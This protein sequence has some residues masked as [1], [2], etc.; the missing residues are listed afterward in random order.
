M[1]GLINKMISLTYYVWVDQQDDQ[2]LTYYVWVDHQDDQ[3][4][5]YYV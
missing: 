1:C 5:T 4:L 2:S 3:S